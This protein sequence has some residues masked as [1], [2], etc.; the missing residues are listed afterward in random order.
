[1]STCCE[2]DISFKSR[3]ALLITYFS[4]HCK[5]YSIRNILSLAYATI[6]ME[7][8]STHLELEDNISHGYI[9]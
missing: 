6:V 3:W 7:F 5:D 4:C 8:E 1:M 2:F 9:P